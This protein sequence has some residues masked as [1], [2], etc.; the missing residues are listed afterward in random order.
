M[1]IK[2]KK[3]HISLVDIK[4]MEIEKKKNTFF[5]KFKQEKNA[6][7][8]INWQEHKKKITGIKSF[9]AHSNMFRI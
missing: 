1:Q 6:K 4:S 7:H 3:K 8:L 9:L 2:K 5:N